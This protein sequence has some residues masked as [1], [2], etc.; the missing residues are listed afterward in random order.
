MSR[1]PRLPEEVFQRDHEFWSK[2][3]IGLS[4]IGSPTIHPLKKL[5]ILRKKT[6]I[7]HDFSGFK[8]DRK[9]VRDDDAQK[10]FS[11]LRSSI[12]GM[13]AY[14][15]SPQCSPTYRPKN[16]VEHQQLVREA[17]F[18]FKQSFAFCPYSPEAVFRYVNLLLS[19]NRLDDALIVAQTCQKLDPYND[20]VTSLVGQLDQFKKQG[21]SSNRDSDPIATDGKR[22]PH[23]YPLT[24][25]IC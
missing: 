13:Y 21:R 18:A 10:A 25:I 6:Y 23:Q 7:R 8:G 24:F 9:F 22:S 15:L 19:L 2:Y 12:A 5:L 4:A 20:Q 14:R 17:D 16:D 1:F 3:P 11:K